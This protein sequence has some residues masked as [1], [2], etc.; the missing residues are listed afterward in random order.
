MLLD[1]LKRNLSKILFRRTLPKLSRTRRIDPE[2][3]RS[4]LFRLIFRNRFVEL[5]RLLHNFVHLLMVC[6]SL[7]FKI[8][9]ERL[10]LIIRSIVAER[11]NRRLNIMLRRHRRQHRLG[12]IKLPRLIPRRPRP[13]IAP[14]TLSIALS[15]AITPTTP[16]IIPRTILARTITTRCFIPR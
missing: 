1:I 2:R 9:F 10:R 12:R 15:A 8:G 7:R 14:S 6:L 5:N 13:F 11:L 4:I 16:R 3:C